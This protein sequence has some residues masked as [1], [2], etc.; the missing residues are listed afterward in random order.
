MIKKTSEPGVRPD[1]PSQS[2]AAK[3]AAALQSDKL[4]LKAAAF[5]DQRLGAPAAQKAAAK[6]P[7]KF[8][9]PEEAEAQA[10]VVPAAAE[11]D[12]SAGFVKTAALAMSDAG[13]AADMGDAGAESVAVEA[14]GQGASGSS[15]PAANSNDDNDGGGIGTT[16]LIIGGLALVGGGIA[17]AAGGGKKNTPPTVT[18]SQAVTVAE[19]GKASITVAATDADS[20][21][22]TYAAST[23][24]K[25]TVSGS[26][27]S[28]TYVPNANF[29]GTDSF[30]VTV[31]DGRGGSVTQTVNIT[32]TPVNDLPVA[33]AATAKV[34]EDGKVT[35]NITATDVDGDTLSYAVA[36]SAVAGL[37]VATNGAFTFDASNAAYQSLAVGATKV[38]TAPISV[39]DGKGGVVQT[40]LTVTVT[41]VNDA[42][43][44]P[45]AT[46]KVTEDAKVTGQIAAS[47]VDGDTLTFAVV[48][49]APAGLSVAA[50]G[51]FTF[52][53]SNAAY[54]ALA[55]GQTQVV[56]T[57]ISVADGKGGTVQTSLAVTVTGVNDAPTVAATQAV[58]AKEDAGAVTF[59]VTGADVDTGD[60]LTYSA[61]ATSAN[62]GT[63]TGGANGEFTYNPAANFKG[64][65][66]VVVTVTDK[67]GATT[68]QTVTFNVASDPE[69]TSTIDIATNAAT[70]VTYDAGGAGLTLGDNFK[71]TDNSGQPTNARIVNFTK[72]DTIEVTAAASLYSFTSNAAGDIEI[73]YN[74]SAT[75]A[76]NLITLVGVLGPGAPFISSEASAEAALGHDFFRSLTLPAGTGTGGTLDADDDGNLAT[77]RAFAGTAAADALTE[78]ALVANFARITN[79]TSGDTITVSN[80]TAGTYSFTGVGTDIRID[81]N[82]SGVTSTIV[83]VNANPT[84]AFINS[85]AS[86]EAAFGADFFRFATATSPTT[87]VVPG[88]A[89]AIDNGSTLS[90]LSAGT[91]AFN[92]T[93]AANRET[94]VVITGFTNDDRIT[95][96]GATS[97]QYSF[98]TA[99]AGRDLVITFNNTAAGVVNNI[100]LDDVLVG[101]SAFIFDYATARTA[102]GFDFMVFG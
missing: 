40:T 6:K 3:A 9:L 14:D 65:D 96:S 101:S 54:Q 93:D 20:D 30:T 11:G 51:A 46:A 64:T 48:G 81:A 61:P 85:E 58:A 2:P 16:P 77:A 10:S 29:N 41:G 23:P 63:V 27:G 86:A 26:G 97:T 15:A 57:P 98:G 1:T 91:G 66:T 67:L 42:P 55:E 53:A 73:V 22:L 70:A 8:V 84:G 17:L 95:V 39:S 56:T 87:P 52:D 88:T 60:V 49:T 37:T 31:T 50:N 43:V 69:E 68:T 62:G 80:A 21:P 25:G 72:G 34:D 32:V 74:N 7:V 19:D 94:N 38:V 78:D 99:D 76:L 100:V 90:T 44:A 33:T 5:A 75:G 102:L 18:A 59:K 79:F 82:V 24:S 89:T 71:F 47:D 4:A 92:F 13:G 12:S 45:A 28:F 35:G 83:L 36:G